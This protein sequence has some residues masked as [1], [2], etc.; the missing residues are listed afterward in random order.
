MQQIRETILRIW[1]G[2][3]LTLSGNDSNNMRELYLLYDKYAFYNQLSQRLIELN[4]LNSY[5]TII[6]FDQSLI[7][8]DTA[9]K[10]CGI[11]YYFRSDVKVINFRISPWIIGR[12]G[13]L[14]KKE[15]TDTVH[16]N[17]IGMTFLLIFEH[18][19]T[20]LIFTLWEKEGFYSC[21]HNDLFTCVHNSFF[22]DGSS[23]ISSLNYDI[24]AIVEKHGSYPSPP[25][26]YL[27]YTYNNNS[28]YLD[29]LLTLMLFT[30]SSVF[31][32]AIF[33]TNIDAIDYN[34]IKGEFKSPCTSGMSK[35]EFVDTI[36]H[37]QSFL[38]ADYMSLINNNVKECRD[39]RIL[40]RN[41]YPDISNDKGKWNIYSA[42]EIYDLFAYAF[43][44]LLCTNYPFV[45]SKVSPANNNTFIKSHVRSIERRSMF[46]FWE[47]MEPTEDN[48][49][50]ILWDEFDCDVL[51]FRN[52][53]FPSITNYGSITPE[54]IR[55]PSYQTG[56]K[57]I[58]KEKIMKDRAF[59]EYIINNKYEMVGAIML[60]GAKPGKSGGSHYTAHIKV[61]SY[62][63]NKEKN[64][65]IRKNVWME[66]NDI[67]D[68]W[69]ITGNIRSIKGI[70]YN[71]LGSFDDNILV[72]KAGVKPEMYFY[73]K[74]NS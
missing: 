61:R 23:A 53:G 18:Q 59:G 33:A 35:N 40:L 3:E 39:I 65:H 6:N 45:I 31:R 73:A 47:F 28:C 69:K 46:T 43:P 21:V 26:T 74:I 29:S 37:L 9:H 4:Q 38:F 13:N 50:Y 10:C 63:T 17:S 64:K 15:L 11:S 51:V 12:I 72:E 25:R 66:Y 48:M 71:S 58:V 42:P 49:K 30:K 1:Y 27:R 16:T 55:V 54:T 20:H 62:H 70:E 57:K 24:Y 8:P 44:S 5:K 7:P 22:N 32:D 60:H 56:K 52:G 68:V 19:L 14:D 67:G 41:C 34:N 36:Q 2:N